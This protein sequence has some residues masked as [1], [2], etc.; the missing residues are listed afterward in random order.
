MLNA[1]TKLL[2]T[3]EI[4]YECPLIKRTNERHLILLICFISGEEDWI[5]GDSFR[6]T[7]HNGA[8]LGKQAE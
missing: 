7:Q 3:Y 8:A 5:R 2:P 4:T 6:A 1:Y